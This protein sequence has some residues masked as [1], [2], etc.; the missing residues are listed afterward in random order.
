M[1]LKAADY[2]LLAGQ[3]GGGL[4]GGMF[5]PEGQ[6]RQSF[7]GTDVSPL[8]MMRQAN[9]FT[10]NFGK[11]LAGRAANGVSV[12]SAVVQQPGA[13]TG[14]GMVMPIGVVASDPALKNPA[15]LRRD[16]LADFANLFSGDD[17]GPAPI[18]VPDGPGNYTPPF[19]GG[20]P[21]QDE[22]ES[23]N[24]PFDQ[25]SPQNPNGTSDGYEPGERN[26]AEMR[27]PRRRSDVNDGTYGQLV[28]ATDLD[29]EDDLAQGI[30]S[31]ELLLE[32]L[33]GRI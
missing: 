18:G 23:R 3:L 13:Y 4:L 17:F 19:M 15:L 12:P 28:R 26:Q 10:T 25:R 14:G 2:A 8:A 33:G 7:E 9:Q 32:A 27:G 1:G 5:A 29:A 31:V 11:A 30:G 22:S 24:P 21:P 6:E 16:G 20:G